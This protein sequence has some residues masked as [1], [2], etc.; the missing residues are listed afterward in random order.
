MFHM[1]SQDIDAAIETFENET[2]D[3]MNIFANRIMSDAN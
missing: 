3:L 1:I 2:F